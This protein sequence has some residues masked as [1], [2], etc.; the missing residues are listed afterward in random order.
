L[1]Q[2]GANGKEAVLVGMHYY[3][4]GLTMNG[5]GSKALNFGNPDNKQEYNGKEKQE[6]EFADGSG[7][8]WLDY[9]A[10]MYD[11]QIGKWHVIDPYTEKIRNIGTS[12]YAYAGNNPIHRIDE[13]GNDWTISTHTNKRNGKITVTFMFTTTIYNQSAKHYTP[14]EMN[15]IRCAIE[16]NMPKVFSGNAGNVKYNVVASVRVINNLS[17]RVKQ[18]HLSEFRIIIMQVVTYLEKKFL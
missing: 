2:F 11:A 10:R 18:E 9:S 7:L 17:D 12:T 16:N 5:L 4:F 14:E 15:D 1:I 6:K 8:E 3:P 13:D